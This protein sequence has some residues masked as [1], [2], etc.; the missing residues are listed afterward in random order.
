MDKTIIVVNP[1]CHQK[2]GWKRWLSIRDDI[3]RYLPGSI[4]EIVLE[5]GTFM[6]QRLAPLLLQ[7]GKK[8]LI[9]AGGDGSINY[10]VNYL[11]KEKQKDLPSIT[12][13]AIGLGSSNDFLK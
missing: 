12:L 11:I 1:D 10:L 3:Y 7:E 8:L 5:Q 6:N 9:S 2:K 13:G 4:E